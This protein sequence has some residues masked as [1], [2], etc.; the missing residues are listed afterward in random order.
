MQNNKCKT[1]VI[2]IAIF[3]VVVVKY[4]HSG[5]I[6]II[7]SKFNLGIEKDNIMSRLVHNK[8]I[9]NINGNTKDVEYIIYIL[10]GSQDTLINSY[11]YAA[12]LYKNNN[13]K[14]IF[15][16]DR[17]SNKKYYPIMDKSFTN[18][19]WSVNEL[20]KHGVKKEIIKF[21]SI[22]KN[23]FGTFSEAEEMSRIAAKYGYNNIILVTSEYHT[24]RAFNSFSYFSKKC[25]FELFVYGSKDDIG[26]KDCL[27]EYVKY[28]LYEYFLL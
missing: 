8:H 18:N 3:I 15:I 10:G 26:I 1:L 19:E 9:Y 2:F 4:I 21:V 7:N 6:F 17:H 27:I 13:I 28:L 20:E 14:H 12:K 16:L 22:P 24:K 25:N 5:N 23:I 11:I